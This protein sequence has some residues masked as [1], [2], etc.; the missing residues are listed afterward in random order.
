MTRVE[1]IVAHIDVHAGRGVEIEPVGPAE[2][3]ASGYDWVIVTS[4]NGARQLGERL[5]GSPARIAAIESVD[6]ASAEMAVR[7]TR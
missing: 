2:V 7:M 4:A 6:A 3:E 1:K 5:C